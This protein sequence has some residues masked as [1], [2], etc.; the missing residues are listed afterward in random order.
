VVNQPISAATSTMPASPSSF[1][2]RSN[3]PWGTSRGGGQGGREFVGDLLA[4]I[5]EPGR[6]TGDECL[7]LGL[8]QPTLFDAD[9]L[10]FV[11]RVVGS[12]MAVDHVGGDLDLGFGQGGA[13]LEVGSRRD[14]GLRQRGIGQPNLRRSR[15]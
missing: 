11:V 5:V 14:N 4:G 8:G 12:P 7:N 2:A 13:G 3:R 15:G 9:D 1:R 10:V 6:H